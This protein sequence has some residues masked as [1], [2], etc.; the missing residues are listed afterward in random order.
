[1]T[2]TEDSDY[3]VVPTFSN[4]VTYSDGKITVPVGVDSF[5]VSYETKDDFEVESNETVQLTVGGQTATG[6]ITDNDLRVASVKDSTVEEG[7]NLSFEVTLNGA[8][9]QATEFDFKLED[10]TAKEGSDYAV[11]PT[12][13]NGVTY[14]DGKITVLAGVE[15]FTVSYVTQNDLDIETDETV[16]LT[17][18][19]ET[20]TG[21][22]TDNDLR[23]ES[24]KDSTVEE[25]KNLSFEVTL[26]GAAKQATEFDFKLEDV[27]ATEGTDYAVVATFSNGVTY[28]NGKITVPAGVE[29]FTVSYVTQN[30]LD[31]ETDETVKLTVGGETATGTITDNDLRVES[32]KDSTVEEGKNLSFEVTLNGA[33]KQATEF[34]FKLEDIT[35]EE[36]LDYA[37]VP[38]FSNGVTYSNGKITVPEGVKS[39]T[40]SYATQNDSE[41]ETDETVQLTIGGQTATGT[42]IDND[43]VVK[44]IDGNTTIEGQELSFKV[45][46]NGPAKQATEFDF[47][48]E[49]ITAEEGS[50]YVVVPKFSD[51]AIKYDATTGKITVPAGV[52]SFTVSYVTEDDVLVEKDEIVQLTIGGQTATGKITDNDVVV[53]SVSNTQAEEGDS[54]EFT[55]T[56]SGKTPHD[57]TFDLVLKSGSATSD[58]FESTPVFSHPDITYDATTG[59]VTV[60]EGIDSF[61]VTYPTIDDSIVERDETV[62][63][64]VGGKTA[65]G[66]ITD[67]EVVIE[68]IT[69]SKV[70]EG[71]G[72]KF[73]VTLSGK[74]P[75]DTTFDFAITPGS[76]TSADYTNT[77]IFSDPAIKYNVITGQLTVPAGIDSFTVTYPTVDDSIVEENET[78]QFTIGG[79]TV[80]G[81]IIDNDISLETLED[82][83]LEVKLPTDGSV[84]GYIIHSLPQNGT[85][86]VVQKDGTEILVT[87]GMPVDLD[88]VKLIFKPNEDW[89]GDTSFTYSTVTA[90]GAESKPVAVDIAVTPVADAPNPVLVTEKWN[91]SNVQLNMTVWRDLT[92]VVTG[93]D[94]NSKDIEYILTRMSGNQP[95]GNAGDGAYQDQLFKAF[96]YLTSQ[97]G[98]TDYSSKLDLSFSPTVNQLHSAGLFDD[99][100]ARVNGNASGGPYVKGDNIEA[101]TGVWMSGYVYLE[102]GKTYSFYGSVD[103]SGM[104]IIGDIGDYDPATSTEE[105]DNL[106]HVNWKGTSTNAKNFTVQDT[107]FY[108]FNFYM[109]NANTEGKFH[110]AVGTDLL[111]EQRT[112]TSKAGDFKVDETKGADRPYKYSGEITAENLSQIKFTYSN[113]EMV[114]ILKQ[115]AVNPSKYYWSIELKTQLSSIDMTFVYM[116]DLAY[117][118]DLETASAALNEFYGSDDISVSGEIG[119]EDVNDKHFYYKIY[120]AREGEVNDQIFLGKFQELIKDIDG[121]EKLSLKFSGLIEGT[122]I[123]AISIYG[124]EEVLGIAN[125][126]GIIEV[127]ASKF[128]SNFEVSDLNGA[129]LFATVPLGYEVVKD[130]TDSMNIKVEATTTEITATGEHSTATESFDILVKLYSST[131]DQGLTSSSADDLFLT[132]NGE[133]TI[134]FNVLN[135]ADKTA[136]NGKD[137]WTDYQTGDQIE[138]GKG[139]FDGLL[140]SDLNNVSQVAKFISVEADGKGNTVVKVDRDGDGSAYQKSD[141]LILQDQSTTTLKDLL[142][143]H[144]IV[145]IG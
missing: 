67:N 36:G 58:D 9:K 84:T 120:G 20:A 86:Y 25:G 19:G 34:D 38:T 90:D 95:A 23:V 113:M 101:N 105:P 71:S 104:I 142:D 21:T 111:T 106:L 138:F 27:T 46:L 110:F 122:K 44:A 140:A 28:S 26:N 145:I 118:P 70:L 77:P 93:K 52:E 94:N 89:S 13:S 82:N 78:V 4:G 130:K 123:I 116:N 108:T 47:K 14:S 135:Q 79:Q 87:K 81:T 132:G 133:D 68:T 137:T 99:K 1:M 60:P 114:P 15:S 51:P 83:Q 141:L 48:L 59:K 109:H 85:L 45:T 126:K 18:G 11:V 33:A 65:T 40:V 72:L 42:I 53:K 32:V 76:A 2:A 6:T 119:K 50:D 73:D 129:S 117:Y 136:G 31:I 62:Q 5:T 55:V 37:D 10:I 112:L 134:I 30:D 80:L 8:A 97:K 74:T 96:E 7:K 115:D 102:K 124:D 24:V 35:A 49:D 103:D 69:G 57:T 29:S 16:K 75:H 91:P 64:T 143:N 17:V 139:F 61:T 92:K 12:F 88:E 144:Q 54:L 98:L 125:S 127:D 22:I 121:S 3:A 100:E 131:K 66:T 128:S 63:L 107:G 43:L 39:F 41:I 56:L